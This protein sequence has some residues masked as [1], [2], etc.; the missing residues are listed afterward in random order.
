MVVL[1][2]L[3]ISR[4]MQQFK[5]W[6]VLKIK[7]KFTY[8]IKLVQNFLESLTFRV[9]LKVNRNLL[10]IYGAIK[11]LGDYKECAKKLTFIFI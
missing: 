11:F 3:E 8:I 10:I 6:N 5:K 7:L 4:K 9:F 1:N 2:P